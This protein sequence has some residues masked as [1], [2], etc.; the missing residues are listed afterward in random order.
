LSMTTTLMPFSAARSMISSMFGGPALSTARPL[1]GNRLPRLWACAASG[2]KNNNRPN[3]A[4]SK[5]DRIYPRSFNFVQAMLCHA[6]GQCK[7]PWL[8]PA[9][10]AHRRDQS[11]DLMKI[12]PEPTKSAKW[13]HFGTAGLIRS[14]QSPIRPLAN[15]LWC[16]TK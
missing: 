2:R 13:W 3:K 12:I 1:P 6:E 16:C 5:S 15:P 10:C 11:L 4:A 14:K 9:F 7:R 8:P